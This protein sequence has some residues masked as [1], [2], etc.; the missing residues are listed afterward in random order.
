MAGC[1]HMW[2]FIA[3]ATITGQVA[4]SAAL[5]SRLSAWPPASLASVFADAG[6]MT[7]TSAFSTSARWLIGSC[8]GAGSPGYDAAQRVALELVEQDRRAGQRRE[9]RAADELLARRRLHDAHRV[10][11]LGGQ[12]D[13]LQRLVGR[14]PPA[15]AEQDAGTR[16]RSYRYWYLILPAATSSS[17]I[18]R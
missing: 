18:V 8:A 13:Q 5:V 6:A 2:L 17:A 1:S 15:D 7:K 4:A 10:A 11:G 9:R 14:D 16:A 3:G 12:P